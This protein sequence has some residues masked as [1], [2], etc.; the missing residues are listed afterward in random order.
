MSAEKITAD[1]DSRKRNSIKQEDLRAKRIPGEKT[2]LTKFCAKPREA[3]VATRFARSRCRPIRPEGLVLHEQRGLFSIP[4]WG[5]L[6][7]LALWHEPR[8]DWV[9]R[10]S[11]EQW[12]YKIREKLLK[13][14]VSQGLKAGAKGSRRKTCQWNKHRNGV[15]LPI[16][17]IEWITRTAEID[18]LPHTRSYRELIL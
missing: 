2:I 17:D 7:S 18:R 9:R 10:G 14:N 11:M 3:I 4:R 5:L 16:L 12:A 15:K 8:S 13:I 1:M 6:K